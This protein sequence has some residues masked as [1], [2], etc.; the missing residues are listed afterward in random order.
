MEQFCASGVCAL[1][2]SCL[3]AAR[4]NRLVFL[5]A[6]LFAAPLRQAQIPAVLEGLVV[7]AA[8]G[9]PVPRARVDVLREGGGLLQSA[10]TDASGKFAIQNIPPG[11]YRLTASR[12]GFVPAQYGERSRGSAGRVLAL[13]SRT[14]LKDIV[15]PLM[16]RSAVS[17]RMYDR[18]GDPVVN[19]TV[20]ALRHTYQDG[21]RILVQVSTARTNDLGEYRLFWLL[22]GQYVIS[23]SP[24][25]GPPAP[26]A[27]ESYL[28]V[29]YPGVIDASSATLIDV[30]TGV[31]LTG[32]D[33][34]TS[35]ARAT[36]VRG[37]LSD[38]MTNSQ[39]S[40]AT[41][42]LVPKR[43]TV[44]TGSSQRATV[45]GGGAFEFR[46]IAPGSYDLVATF[47]IGGTK[48]AASA[49]IEA[50]GGDIDNVALVLQPQFD[51]AGRVTI[52]N[53]GVELP[54]RT[55][56]IRV[57]LRRDPYTPELLILLPFIA[58]DGTFALTNVT[59]GDYQ[60]RVRLMGI[61]GYVKSAR[62]GAADAFNPPF[63]VDSAGRLEVVI[64]LNAGTIDA[65]VDDDGQKPSSEATVVLVPDPPR[66]QRFDLY[67]VG[68][69]DA[70]GH[71][72]FQGIAPGDYKLFAWDDVPADAW[73]DPDF[74]RAY[75]DRGR[76]VH[77]L[78][79]SQENL[80]AKLIVRN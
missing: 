61:N 78:E 59:P 30:P 17:G 25:D 18:Y 12:D 9:T 48:L 72:H 32:V 3:C 10:L 53:A 54:V 60:L 65:V 21:R 38:G 47:G 6:F 79:G 11:R 66:R 13:D 26:D 27:A 51:V 55:S 77:I 41:V 2:F 5:A 70:A 69:S 43:G 29:Y 42:L 58:A 71:V 75:E 22:P 39:V 7:A 31:N 68:G 74:L 40:G 50:R 23:G 73:L 19:A 4:R 20:Q 67:Q 45:A 33:L 1:V 36:R 49:S 64:S 56:D 63:H 16:Q 62:F 35:D 76:P 57:E 37:R 15:I 34:A 8:T 44:A 52:E 14:Q 46:H 28:P 24:A 80:E